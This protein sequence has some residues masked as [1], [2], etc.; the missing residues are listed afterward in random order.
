MRG[1]YDTCGEPY[2]IGPI[3]HQ[4]F[5]PASA[6]LNMGRPA[7]PPPYE[8]ES[9]EASVDSAPDLPPRDPGMRRQESATNSATLLYE[10]DEPN[11]PSTSH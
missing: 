11:Q 4:E 3:P 7:D 8:S 5:V 6:L 2:Y 10:N 1:A 9:E